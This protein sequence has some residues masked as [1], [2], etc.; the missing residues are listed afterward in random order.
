MNSKKYRIN[1]YKIKKEMRQ[2]ESSY[3]NRKLFNASVREQS[4]IENSEAEKSDS[5]V[6]LSYDPKKNEGLSSE[7][8][9]DEI[10]NEEIVYDEIE[11]DEIEN[12]TETMDLV[13]DSETCQMSTDS[14][15]GNTMKEK[16]LGK[17]N[18]MHF[19]DQLRKWYIKNNPTHE[20][21]KDL[22]TIQK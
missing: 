3:Y 13:L 16:Y 6:F 20:S 17:V 1:Y 10:E 18:E 5:N 21:V 11:N 15:D 9:N 22:L 8:S 19:S 2:A 7:K 12:P 14:S 4:D